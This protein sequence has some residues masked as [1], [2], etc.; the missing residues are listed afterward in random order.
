MARVECVVDVPIDI[1]SAFAVSQTTGAL[2]RQWDPFIRRQYLLDGATVPGAGVRTFT[3]ARLG[4]KM[5]SQYTSFRPPDQVG[6]KM[7]EGPWFFER[8]GG[9]W[10]FSAIDE[11]TT[12]ATWRYTFSVRPPCLSF[13]AVP[14]GRW[15]LDREIRRRIDA[16][17]RACTD[18][19]VVRAA[20]RFERD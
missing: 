2:R 16:F 12:R 10:S 9:G 6:M 5:V 4:P 14:F 8:F 15:L 18:P 3:K 13:V 17:A 19:D 7:V 11:H 20:P 1:V